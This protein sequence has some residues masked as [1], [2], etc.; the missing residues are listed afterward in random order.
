MIPDEVQDLIND[1]K[2]KI[3]IT[4]SNKQNAIKAQDWRKACDLD[5]YSCGLTSALNSVYR[6]FRVGPYKRS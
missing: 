2:S 1:L 5:R 3:A 4:E 6:I